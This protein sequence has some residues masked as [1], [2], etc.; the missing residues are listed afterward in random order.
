M[1]DGEGGSR[2]DGFG[3]REGEGGGGEGPPSRV[4]RREGAEGGAR[5]SSSIRVDRG[6]EIV[7]RAA[8]GRCGSPR[9]PAAPRP[10]RDRMAAVNGR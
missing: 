3:G 8:A 10:L 2:R 6:V 7:V 5:I 1:G 4:R 9:S